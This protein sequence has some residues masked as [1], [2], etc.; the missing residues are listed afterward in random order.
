MHQLLVH[1]MAAVVLSDEWLL[2]ARVLQARVLQQ[3]DSSIGLS[4][5]ERPGCNMLT[6]CCNRVVGA[7]KGQ[8]TAAG[9]LTFGSPVSLGRK[10]IVKST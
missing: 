6:A 4:L 3:L 1:R 10:W 5:E 2:Q 8:R 9:T 7:A